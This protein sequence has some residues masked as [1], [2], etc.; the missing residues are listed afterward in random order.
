MRPGFFL[1]CS[2]RRLAALPSLKEQGAEASISRCERVRAA[3]SSAQRAALKTLVFNAS[4]AISFSTHCERVRQPV[5]GP[6]VEQVADQTHPGHIADPEFDNSF[7]RPWLLRVR[8]RKMTGW[9]ACRQTGRRK[10]RLNR[11]PKQA[12]PG[13]L[14]NPPETINLTPDSRAGN[15]AG[16]GARQGR[17][18]RLL[19]SGGRPIFQVPIRPTGRTGSGD[20]EKKRCWVLR[21]GSRQSRPASAPGCALRSPLLEF[22][23]L[24]H[25]AANLQSL[26]VRAGKVI[27]FCSPNEQ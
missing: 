14:S 3:A 8:F 2:P 26:F 23:R 24:N 13:P 27:C 1:A 18:L 16:R 9:P 17:L 7:V 22:E 20:L 12:M 6:L 21:G 11:R 5:R 19:R 15:R 10:C 25:V 4:S